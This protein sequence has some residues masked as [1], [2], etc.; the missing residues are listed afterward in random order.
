L[1]IPGF[2][3]VEYA[4]VP[5]DEAVHTRCFRELLQAVCNAAWQSSGWIPE[6]GILQAEQV[7]YVQNLPLSSQLNE[8]AQDVHSS[9]SV[10][11]GAV[12]LPDANAK[13]RNESVQALAA[14]G[15]RK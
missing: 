8:V 1:Q 9:F 15:R 3:D 14:E 4:S 6:R 11:L 13:V 10:G 5:V 7:R 2:A 12:P